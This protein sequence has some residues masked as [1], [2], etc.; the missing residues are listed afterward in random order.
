MTGPGRQSLPRPA[1]ALALAALALLVAANLQLARL[2]GGADGSAPA[3]AGAGPGPP[4]G[5]PLPEPRGGT[6]SSLVNEFDDSSRRFE[7]MLG[8]LRGDLAKAAEGTEPLG[9]LPPRLA[10]LADESAR[11]SVTLRSLMVSVTALAPLADAAPAFRSLPES[12]DRLA[13]PLDALGP[14]RR[15]METLTTSTTGLLE[16][17]EPLAATT[18]S[19]RDAITSLRVTVTETNAELRHL[20]RCLE[21][22]VLCRRRER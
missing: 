14:L 21:T 17:V 10:R 4:G 5:G 6:A 8:D 13:G 9:E 7:R 20:G 15:Q 18:S 2:D 1:L 22:P 16:A 3:Q 19:T 12:M 11:V